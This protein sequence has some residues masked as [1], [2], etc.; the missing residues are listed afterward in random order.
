MDIVHK[1]HCI[2]ASAILKNQELDADGLAYPRGEVHHVINPTL[3]ITSPT[4]DG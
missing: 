1:H 2:V 4:V 3:T